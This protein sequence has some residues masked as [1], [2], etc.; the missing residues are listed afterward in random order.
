MLILEH[1]LALHFYIFIATT[2][3]HGHCQFKLFRLRL[4]K[5]IFGET[6]LSKFQGKLTTSTPVRMWN[7]EILMLSFLGPLNRI[8]N[9]KLSLHS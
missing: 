8:Q 9:Q 4:V 7:S 5:P 6:Y 3:K 1:E 2:Q